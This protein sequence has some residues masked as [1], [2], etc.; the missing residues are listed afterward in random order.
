MRRG[1]VVWH[2]EGGRGM[3]T[4]IVRFQIRPHPLAD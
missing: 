3:T 4:E 2:N 1:I